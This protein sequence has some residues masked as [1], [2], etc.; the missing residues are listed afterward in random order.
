MED[1]ENEPDVNKVVDGLP[2]M[3]GALKGLRVLDLSRYIAGPYCGMLLGDLGADVVKVE[4]PGKGENTRAFYPRIGDESIYTMV[5]NR[6]KRGITLNFRSPEGQD[7]LRE[8]IKSSDVVVENFLPGTLEKMGCGWDTMHKLNPRLIMTR[9][10]GFGSTGPFANEPC[11]DLIAQAMSGLM[12]LTGQKDGPP[13]MAGSF[14]ADYTTGLYAT[15]GTLAALSHRA[16]TG[17]GQLVESTLLS[18]A[19]SLLVTAIPKHMLLGETTTRNGN[20]DRFVAPSNT[21]PTTDNAWIILQASTEEKFAFMANAMGRPDLPT[22]PRFDSNASRMQNV[23]ELEQI[24]TQWSSAHTAE[25]LLSVLKAGKVPSAKVATIA[26]VV[27]NPQVAHDEQI[28][29]LDQAGGKVPMQGFAVRLS[30]TPLAI[31]H[32]TPSIGEHTDSVLNEWL[33]YSKDDVTQLQGKGAI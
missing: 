29:W 12:D 15:I 28:I 19:M 18:S 26:D 13:T 4:T 31:R 21:F 32:S 16:T 33:D 9:I 8:L 10:S 11:F 25:E 30:D 7:V 5:F 27:E 22:D 20:R 14:V 1:T 23:E 6:N 17:A 24:I 3:S 2:G